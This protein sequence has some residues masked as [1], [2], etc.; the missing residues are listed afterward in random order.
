MPSHSSSSSFCATNKKDYENNKPCVPRSI[1]NSERAYLTHALRA[2]HY[3][4]KPLDSPSWINNLRKPLPHA[5]LTHAQDVEILTRTYVDEVAR[6]RAIRDILP[7]PDDE[8]QWTYQH[9]G[10]TKQLI[11]RDRGVKKTFARGI[12]TWVVHGETK[13]ALLDEW[14]RDVWGE[15]LGWSVLL[16]D[17]D[18]Y[19]DSDD[20]TSEG[21]EE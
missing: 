11:G 8:G 9:W 2:L 21:E 16:D 12:W 6:L 18:T 7:M 10:A 3:E 17:P 13:E 5:D 1:P 19:E 15:P 14:P 4:D 20:E